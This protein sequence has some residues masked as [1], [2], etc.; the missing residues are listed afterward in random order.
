MAALSNFVYAFIVVAPAVPTPEAAPG[1]KVG[2]LRPPFLGTDFLEA[3]LLPATNF[4]TALEVDFLAD[5]FAA[6]FATLFP[7][8][9]LAAEGV[10]LLATLVARRRGTVLVE[11]CLK[12][13]PSPAASTTPWLTAPLLPLRGARAGLDLAAAA[14]AC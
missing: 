9:T 12:F 1:V 5:A 10:G 7:P 14:W 3:V 11:P 13:Q 8:A 6:A 4:W 2:V